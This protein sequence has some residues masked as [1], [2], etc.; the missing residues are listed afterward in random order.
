[1]ITATTLSLV[2]PLRVTKGT[3]PKGGYA[4]AVVDAIIDRGER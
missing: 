4:T 3:L 1:M 2:G